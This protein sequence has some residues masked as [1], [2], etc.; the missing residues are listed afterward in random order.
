M[1]KTQR[2]GPLKAYL[3]TRM[4][5]P[6]TDEFV[7]AFLSAL[8]T[9]R[10]LA[11]WLLYKNGGHS[12]LLSLECQPASYNSANRFRDDYLA[13]NLLSKSVF[14]NTSIDKK[15]VALEKFFLF[16][17]QCHLTN[18]RF[19]NLSLDPQFKGSN[20][21]LL[22]ATRRKIDRILGGF[23]PD[24]FVDSCCWGPGNS[25]SLTGEEVSAFNKFHSESGITRDLYSLVG[26]WFSV[27]YPTWARLFT[28][29]VRPQGHDF[30]FQVGNKVITV[31]KNAK[32]DRVIAVEP[33]INLWFQQGV[34][35]MIKRRLGRVGID[36]TDQKRNQT[37]AYDA[38]KDGSLATVDFSSASDSIA[39]AVVEDLLPPRW[40]ALLDCC[41]S[42]YRV[43]EDLKAVWWNKFS[44]MGNAFTF[45]LQSLIFYA[46]AV[47]CCE[48][49]GISKEKV[50]VYGD[51]VIIPVGAY[52]LFSEF[53]AFLG[54]TV[55][56]LK[57]FFSGPFRESCGA[58]YYEGIDCKPLYLKDRIGAFRHVFRTA[59]A[60]R[61]LAH[62]IGASLF[63]DSRFEPCFRALVY[64][65]PASC[66]FRISEGFGDG[67]F[68]SNWDEATPPRAKDGIEGYY[69]SSFVEVGVSK[70]STER[71]ILLARL[72]GPSIQENNNRYTLRG[73]T[74][75]SIKRRMLVRRWHN[76]GPW[77]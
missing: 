13:T 47:S 46:A 36:L 35:N 34:G 77:M 26:S 38:S 3:T 63:C 40:F 67:G 53:S 71:A 29:E 33:G 75:T 76:L 18:T 52:D 23:N 73:R 59:N 64:A 11:V 15:K 7:F 65:I 20:V 56:G 24:E 4:R 57:S 30:H 2:E 74:R 70:A 10:S 55:N 48:Y 5:R 68:I 19:R 60:V 58:H 43:G 12:D 66:R 25:T 50:S 16:E 42:K 45:P 49:L 14:L 17:E 41:R 54:F 8:D 39:L 62:R 21:W 44:S 37:L 69:Q 27:A 31:P 22:N 9:P 28:P 1:S 51:D 6:T 32:T 61:R 72:W